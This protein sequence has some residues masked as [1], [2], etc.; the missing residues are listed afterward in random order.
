MKAIVFVD[1]D[2]TIFQTRIKNK[3]GFIP[4][5]NTK[6]PKYTSYMTPAQ[7]LLWD[8]I[9]NHESVS[10]I[11]VTLRGIKEYNDTQIS[12][13]PKIITSVLYFS[14]IITNNDYADAV[15]AN[16]IKSCFLK[17]KPSLG[18]IFQELMKNL[19]KDVFKVEI[20]DSFYISIKNLSSGDVDYINQNKALIK[21]IEKK[22]INDEYVVHFKNKNIIILPKFL[23]KKNSVQYLINKYKP[24]LTIGAGDS[25]FDWGFMDLCDYKLIPRDSQLEAFI[26]GEI[27]NYEKR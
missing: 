22:I 13:N 23:N 21:F 3:E 10:I 24:D 14:G 20:V 5:T 12:K 11:P 8:I 16:H 6:N 7:S 18:D 15:W 1:L 17:L 2:E 4:V 27:G 26:N 9:V 19:K 25:L